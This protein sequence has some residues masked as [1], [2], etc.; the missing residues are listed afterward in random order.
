MQSRIESVM[1]QPLSVRSRSR[2]QTKAATDRGKRRDLIDQK[3]IK[4][5][6][7]LEMDRPILLKDKFEV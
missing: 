7:R 3:L 6:D 4:L 2:P 1:E 5:L